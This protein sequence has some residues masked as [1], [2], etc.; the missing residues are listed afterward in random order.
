M[1]LQVSVFLLKRKR[2]ERK[3]KRRHQISANSGVLLMSQITNTMLSFLSWAPSNS[4][5]IVTIT[6][7]TF[8]IGPSWLTSFSS[9]T[10]GS[11]RLI[12]GGRPHPE[13]VRG[14]SW[15]HYTQGSFQEGLGERVYKN[16]GLE[17]G[18]ATCKAKPEPLYYHSSHSRAKMT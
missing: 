8:S 14:Y 2:L 9:K 15:L 18:P 5:Y 4:R 13:M 10:L 7:L 1:A 3:R 11:Y 6:F 16:L 12:L 17:P